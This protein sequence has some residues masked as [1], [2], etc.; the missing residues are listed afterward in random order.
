MLLFTSLWVW[1]SEG[2]FIFA[3]MTSDYSSQLSKSG[4]KQGERGVPVSAPQLRLHAVT[5]LMLLFVSCSHT[6]KNKM[7][8]TWHFS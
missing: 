2:M 8:S 7:R 5:M 4:G 1:N 3:E 6:D